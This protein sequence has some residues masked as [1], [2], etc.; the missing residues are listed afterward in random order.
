MQIYTDGS[1][2][3][4]PGKGGW[5]WVDITNSQ[6]VF[7]DSGRAKRTTNNA[8]ELRA[9]LESFNSVAEDEL[10]A[11]VIHIHTDSYIALT[12][13]S[14]RREKCRSSEGYRASR[15]S[16]KTPE[17]KNPNYQLIM[18][19]KRSKKACIERGHTIILHHVRG[20]VGIPGNELADKLANEARL[21]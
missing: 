4:N 2:S 16:G 15:R 18:D 5:A 19:M 8:M 17:R 11:T 10:P 13:L 14:D 1:C 21:G 12:Y 3:P 7:S 9:L 20:H 6:L